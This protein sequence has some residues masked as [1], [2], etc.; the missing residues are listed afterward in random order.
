MV[1][2]INRIKWK[3]RFMVLMVVMQER[4]FILL[5]RHQI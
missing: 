2:R 3:C 5:Q 4:Y 1:I